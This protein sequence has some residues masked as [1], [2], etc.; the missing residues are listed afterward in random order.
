MSTKIAELVAACR[1]GERLL[2]ELPPPAE[3]M[4]L[5]SSRSLNCAWWTSCSGARSESALILAAGQ[6]VVASARLSFEKRSGGSTSAPTD[7]AARRE[8]RS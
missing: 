5:S 7:E 6:P 8:L 3:T 2:H 1:D 4:R